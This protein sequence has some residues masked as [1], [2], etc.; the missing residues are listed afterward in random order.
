MK[1]PEKAFYRVQVG[2]D[3]VLR[4]VATLELIQHLLPKM[5]YKNLLVPQTLNGL[6]GWGTANAAPSAAPAASNAY[7]VSN[8]CLP[9]RQCQ[10]SPTQ[11]AEAFDVLLVDI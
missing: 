9:A 6:K 8:E 7:V 4:V 10:A 3:R 5:G 2:M 11:T 1:I